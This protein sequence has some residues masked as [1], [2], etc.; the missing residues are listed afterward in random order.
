MKFFIFRSEI[1]DVKEKLQHYQIMCRDPEIH[2]Q[3]LTAIFSFLTFFQ[4]NQA[5]HGLW[6]NYDA[7]FTTNL[8]D[9][10]FQEKSFK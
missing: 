1:L 3:V 4:A 9:R 8:R 7:V 10:D 5:M 2:K 6:R